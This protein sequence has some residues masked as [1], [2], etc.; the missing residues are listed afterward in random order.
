MKRP[1]LAADDFVNGVDRIAEK[2]GVDA[3]RRE[4]FSLGRLP[5]RLPGGVQDDPGGRAVIGDGAQES[6]RLPIPIVEREA[7]RALVQNLEDDTRRLRRSG[8]VDGREVEPYRLLAQEQ[9]A[10]HLAGAIRQG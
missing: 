4:R 8:G 1:S 3:M 7:S 6:P 9:Q 5:N 2:R 10:L